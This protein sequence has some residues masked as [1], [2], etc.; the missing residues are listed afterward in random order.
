MKTI[1]KLISN[2]TFLTI[3]SGTSVYAISQLFLEFIVN[4]RKEF[5]QLKQ[6]IFYTINMNKNY[7]LTPYDLLKEDRNVRPKSEYITASL[8]LKKIGSEFA[9]YV[10]T[11]PKYRFN[12]RKK[13]LEVQQSLIGLSNG[14]YIYKNYNPVNDNIKCEK[15]ILDNL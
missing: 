4:P 1:I 8:E 5:K 15:I 12:K 11:I 14:L 3:I 13:L 7:Y 9:S 6:K 10:G 2:Q